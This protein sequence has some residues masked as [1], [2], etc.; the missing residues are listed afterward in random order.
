MR[1]GR[2]YPHTLTSYTYLHL[3]LT[4]C[5]MVGRQ[6]QKASPSKQG[7]GRS[8]VPKTGKRQAAGARD[9]TALACDFVQGSHG[10]PVNPCKIP[11]RNLGWSRRQCSCTLDV[12][13]LRGLVLDEAPCENGALVACQVQTIKTDRPT[14]GSA[15]GYRRQLWGP[16]TMH[17]YYYSQGDESCPWMIGSC[18]PAPCGSG[19]ARPMVSGAREQAPGSRSIYNIRC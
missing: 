17:E 6:W 16:S 9:P 7:T 10:V 13:I 1:R 5:V 19:R 3:L 11:S 18:A 15:R 4:L 12:V 2:S 14:R 8:I